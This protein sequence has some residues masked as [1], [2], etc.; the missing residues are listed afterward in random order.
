MVSYARSTYEKSK[1]FNEKLDELQKTISPT[2]IR[3]YL[4]AESDLKEKIKLNL[5]DDQIVALDEL[6][7]LRMS[8]IQSEMRYAVAQAKKNG[9]QL[10]EEIVFGKSIAPG[11]SKELLEKVPSLGVYSLFMLFTTKELDSYLQKNQ[12]DDNER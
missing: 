12:K 2:I 9:V 3:V 10:S 6:K 5:R 1:Q 4:A 7:A 11:F 8:G